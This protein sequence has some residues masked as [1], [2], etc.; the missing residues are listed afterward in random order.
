MGNPLFSNEMMLL[1]LANALS[2]RLSHLSSRQRCEMRTDYTIIM[3]ERASK[4]KEYRAATTTTSWLVYY[5]EVA[6]ASHTQCA[7]DD[8]GI[9]ELPMSILALAISFI[10]ISVFIS[11]ESVFSYFFF[12]LLFFVVLYRVFKISS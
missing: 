1:S 2:I 10:S 3:E 7:L 11:F 8:E 9:Q 4:L 6:V 12:I 5:L